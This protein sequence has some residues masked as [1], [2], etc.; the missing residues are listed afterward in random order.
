M[1]YNYSND[2]INHY[3]KLLVVDS[4]PQRRRDDYLFAFMSIYVSACRHD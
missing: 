1:L 3:S 2:I 4:T